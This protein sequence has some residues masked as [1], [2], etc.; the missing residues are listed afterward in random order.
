[1]SQFW[2]RLRERWHKVG[3]PGD[4]MIQCTVDSG[5]CPQSPGHNLQKLSHRA[6]NKRCPFFLLS[7]GLTE[8]AELDAFLDLKDISDI[9]KTQ[10]WSQLHPF[11]RASAAI[12]KGHIV[13]LPTES[14]IP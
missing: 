3:N 2:N 13:G 12:Y 4:D 7:S 14:Y 10:L 9:S 5:Q 11:Y 8:T 6:T 1:V